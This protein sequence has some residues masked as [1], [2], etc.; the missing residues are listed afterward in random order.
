MKSIEEL[1]EVK[2]KRILLRASLNAPIVD[3]VVSDSI[4][5]D[6]ALRT[7]NFLLEKGARV[8]L[9]SH[10]SNST[11]SL[12]P[13]Y[14]YLKEKIPVL[15]VDAVVGEVVK[16][17]VHSLSN[18]NALLLQNLRNDPREKMND[19][20]FAGELAS[21]GEIFVNDDFPV[22]HRAH[23]SVVG[24]PKLLPSYAGFQFLDEVKG[25]TPALHP[26]SPSLAIVGG[27]KLVTKVALV[28]TLLK[29]Y[30]HVFVGGAI[31]NDFFK[32]KG[33]ETGMSL[34]SGDD[35]AEKM[36]ANPKILLPEKVTVEAGGAR[37]DI[38]A[39]SVGIDEAVLDIA[40]AS[41]EA[42]TPT[43]TASRSILWNGPMGNFEK[44]YVEGT[45]ALAEAIAKAPGKSIVGGGDTL[46]S[47]QNLGL[48]DKFT[49]VSTAGGAMLD[50]LANGTL[51]GIEALEQSAS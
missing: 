4:R 36:L 40:P 22:S 10:I 6:H 13:I 8:I 21:L 5:I 35:T 12:K 20:E 34:V 48:M 32:A 51:P 27:A 45:D 24:V 2:G 41:I 39:N 50:F 31:A 3:G 30:D 15:F 37:R 43:I 47:I 23:A 19:G 26:E 11:A 42:L 16:N 25:L 49:F 29:K 18:G 1:K 44:G 28:E 9:I 46:S 33:Y 14:D 38:S 7:I 17:A